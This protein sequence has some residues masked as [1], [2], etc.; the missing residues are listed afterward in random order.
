MA[1]HTDVFIRYPE[2][3][4]MEMA[5]DDP[6]PL[7]RRHFTVDAGLQEAVLS[8]CAL[9]LGDA[10]LNGQPVTQDRFIAPISDYS[11]TLWYTEYSVTP[12]LHPGDNLAGCTAPGILMLPPGGTCRSCCFH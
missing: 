8:I 5:W 3:Y 4:P 10:Y 7:F 1:F 6:A 2:P 11:K 12:L 9:G